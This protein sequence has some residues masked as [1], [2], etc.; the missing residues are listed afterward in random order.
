MSEKVER[1]I[2]AL[3]DGPLVCPHGNPIPGLDQLGLPV[4]TT[5]TAVALISLTQA[6][7]AAE[8]NIVID[9]ISEQLQSD[10]ELLHRLDLAGLRPGL[11]VRATSAAGG[12][13]VS[14]GDDSTALFARAISDHVFV[15]AG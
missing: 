9:R 15:R 14:F 5:D 7:A 11:L 12:V 8:S 6:A 4:A 1:R 2:V 10:A 3:L 13:E